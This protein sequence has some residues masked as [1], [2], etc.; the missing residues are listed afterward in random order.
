MTTKE[1]AQKAGVCLSTAIKW[2]A[3]PQNKVAYVGEGYRR[4]YMPTDDDYKRFLQ[5]PKPGKRA[6]KKP[7]PKPLHKAKK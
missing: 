3:N 5:R 7:E 1:L 6:K 2:C 4:T